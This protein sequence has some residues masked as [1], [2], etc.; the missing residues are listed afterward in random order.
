MVH[1]MSILLST[2]STKEVFSPILC[3][4][5]RKFFVEK[6]KLFRQLKMYM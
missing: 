2:F 1:R 5:R 4:F 6:K 3:I